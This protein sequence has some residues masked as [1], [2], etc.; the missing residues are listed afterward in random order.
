MP[1]ICSVYAPTLKMIVEEPKPYRA[2]NSKK[3]LS[4]S[5]SSFIDPSILGLLGSG[6]SYMLAGWS[7]RVHRSKFLSMIIS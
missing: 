1:T 7:P 5:T 2:S 3:Y 4:V 6:A